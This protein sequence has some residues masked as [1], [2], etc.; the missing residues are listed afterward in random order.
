MFGIYS[1]ETQAILDRID[2]SD[3]H[4]TREADR[5]IETVSSNLQESM[6]PIITDINACLEQT[7][8]NTGS[9]AQIDKLLS[10]L[11]TSV[12]A[13]RTGNLYNHTKIGEI[14]ENQEIINSNL[15][16]LHI[17]LKK[18]LTSLPHPITGRCYQFV[19]IS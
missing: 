6:S 5:V 7:K 14:I 3:T 17:R 2:K 13:V 1:V 8:L 10:E 16:S 11:S 4:T 12:E 19:K 9:L 15:A 18:S